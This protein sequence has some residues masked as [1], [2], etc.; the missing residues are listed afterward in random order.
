MLMSSIA[1]S[2]KVCDVCEEP[3]IVKTVMGLPPVC[4]FCG[5]PGM[6][7]ISASDANRLVERKRA[8]ERAAMERQRMGARRVFVNGRE[9]SPEDL[10]NMRG[11]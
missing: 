3:M 1:Y 2:V 11:F 4:P 6:Q 5:A 7:E 9:V 10:V 8:A